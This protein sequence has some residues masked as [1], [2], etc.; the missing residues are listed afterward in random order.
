MLGSFL[1]LAG[2]V[3]LFTP[4]QGVLTLLLGLSLVDFP[5]KRTLERRIVQRPTVLKLV[6]HMRAKADRP[7]LQFTV[8]RM[9]AE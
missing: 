4:G 3:M 5:G 9:S 8:Q 2:V 1:V 7:P 6:N